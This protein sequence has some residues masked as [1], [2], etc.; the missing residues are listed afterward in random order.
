M[1]RSLRRLVIDMQEGWGKRK[2]EGGRGTVMRVDGDVAIS[3][4]L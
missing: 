1:L 2:A 4:R 3:D